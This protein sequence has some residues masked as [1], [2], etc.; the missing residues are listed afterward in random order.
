MDNSIAIPSRIIDGIGPIHFNT[1]NAAARSKACFP[2][3][4]DGFGNGDGGKTAAA[5][6]TPISQTRDGAGNYAVLASGY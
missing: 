2:H 6:E 3:T 1:F 4:R 5:K